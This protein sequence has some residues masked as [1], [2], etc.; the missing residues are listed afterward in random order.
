[1]EKV[2]VGGDWSYEDELAGTYLKNGERIRVRWPDGTEED[3]KVHLE[4]TSTP[5]FDHGKSYPGRCAQA[6]I[7][8]KLHGET[9]LVRLSDTK[10]L[11]E[12]IS[13]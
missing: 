3:H 6:F 9:L 4:V 10:L 5:I 7:K 13:Q 12:R 8:V 11:C 1:M 2:V